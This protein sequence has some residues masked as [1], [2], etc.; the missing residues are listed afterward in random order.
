MSTAT[1]HKGACLCQGIKFTVTGAPT[2]TYCCYCSDCS[3]GA[4]GPC[5]ITAS[6]PRSQVT[7]HD[8]EGLSATYEITNTISGAPKDKCFCKRCGCTI[9]TVPQS[10]QA[11]GCIVIRVALIENG[12]ECFKP[13]IECFTDRRP[14]WFAGCG[15]AEQ[16]EGTS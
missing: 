16:Y 5:Q 7:L 9:Y 15:A 12:L 14:R 4:G 6:Y 13:D 2:A 11:A 8:P 10:T 3:L 1:T